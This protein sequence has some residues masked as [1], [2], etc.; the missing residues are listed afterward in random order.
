M[1]Y[2]FLEPATMWPQFFYDV[3]FF[4]GT[5]LK[6]SELNPASLSMQEVSAQRTQSQTRY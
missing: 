3:A 6:D 2:P 1:T 5:K 4:Q